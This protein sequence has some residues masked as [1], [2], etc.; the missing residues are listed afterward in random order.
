MAQHK[1]L[2]LILDDSVL[3]AMTALEKKATA[4]EVIEE[5]IN[6]IDS[7]DRNPTEWERESLSSALGCILLGTY[8]AARNEALFCLLNKDQVAGPE[9]WWDESEDVT[10]QDLR[11]GL[12][13]ARGA[14]PRGV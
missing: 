3:F 2:D 12:A 14:P 1:A 7:E 8:I 5:I 10:I 13:C 4:E 11:D 6:Y 9:H